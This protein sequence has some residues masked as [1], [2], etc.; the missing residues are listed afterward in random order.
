MGTHGPFLIVAPLST[1]S[2]WKSEFTKF[3][4][5]LKTLLYHGNKTTRS[6]LRQKEMKAPYTGTQFPIIITSYEICMN[7]K[8]HLQYIPWYHNLETL[9]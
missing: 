7:D 5:T 6:K 8:Q 9:C 2:N 1:L 3:A 4:P